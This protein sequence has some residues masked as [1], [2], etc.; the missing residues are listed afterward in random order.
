M[1]SGGGAALTEGAIMSKKRLAD[2]PIA[3]DEIQSM[4]RIVRG[5]RVMLDSDLAKLYGRDNRSAEPS[6]STERRSVP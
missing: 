6:R 2:R 1:T 4:V 3:P 5:Q